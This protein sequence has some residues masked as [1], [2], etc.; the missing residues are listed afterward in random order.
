MAQ[1]TQKYT[2]GHETRVRLPAADRCWKTREEFYSGGMSWRIV[3]SLLKDHLPFLLK[4][5]VLIGIR[6]G[7]LFFSVQLFF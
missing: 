3:D 2:Y 7:G 5:V 1:H 6:R 4:P